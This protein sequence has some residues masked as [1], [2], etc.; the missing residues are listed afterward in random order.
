MYL[1]L[2]IL[3]LLFYQAYASISSNFN[4]KKYEMPTVTTP[5]PEALFGLPSPEQQ[6]SAEQQQQLEAMMQQGMTEKQAMQQLQQGQM[7]TEGQLYDPY[8]LEQNPHTGE[9]QADPYG[10]ES[11]PLSDERKAEAQASLG[12]I[13]YKAF[14]NAEKTEPA[15]PVI[16]TEKAL[17]DEKLKQAKEAIEE[18]LGG[19]EARQ[20]EQSAFA[21]AMTHKNIGNHQRDNLAKAAAAGESPVIKAAQD[22][23]IKDDG[24]V[25]KNTR[26]RE[27]DA[28]LLAF[29]DRNNG[30]SDTVM[31]KLRKRVEHMRKRIGVRGTQSRR[32]EQTEIVRE[33]AA[34]AAPVSR[35]G[36]A[37]ELDLTNNAAAERAFHQ[38]VGEQVLSRL[39]DPNGLPM[40]KRRELYDKAMDNPSA[41]HKLFA[42]LSQRRHGDLSARAYAEAGAAI[43]D[44]TE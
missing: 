29:R 1:C 19:T 17:K 6:L 16:V 32:S 20:L 33:L 24:N 42:A 2:L 36:G 35:G 41:A 5:Q 9:W 22:P 4:T 34:A 37:K 39:V 18:A 44:L 11:T 7:N 43:N 40:Q 25:S 30:A 3:L 8:A 23:L 15:N 38:I 26:Q 28:E 27:Q 13:A 14:E 21:D 10:Q 12:E 31:G